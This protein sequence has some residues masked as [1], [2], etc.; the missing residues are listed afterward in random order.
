ML[1]FREQFIQFRLTDHR[2]ER[3]LRELAGREIVVLDLDDGRWRTDQPDADDAV[4]TMIAVA[5]RDVDEARLA[6]W[7]RER[8]SFT[9]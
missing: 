3:R 6:G 7:L 5:E 4:E 2:T 9:D 1:Q 8:V